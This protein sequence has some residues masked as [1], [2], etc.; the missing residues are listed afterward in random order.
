MR[1]TLKLGEPVALGLA[2]GPVV[3]GDITTDR[4]HPVA[5][6]K[7]LKVALES[8]PPINPFILQGLTGSVGLLAEYVTNA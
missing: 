8:N 1:N 7:I 4:Y 3:S 5:P 6:E 2:Q